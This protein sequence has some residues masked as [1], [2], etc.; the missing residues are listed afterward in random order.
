MVE[1]SRPPT[2][3]LPGAWL[4]CASARIHLIQRDVRPVDP[5]ADLREASDPRHICVDVSDLDASER[6][7]AARGFPCHRSGTAG[8]QT[9]FRTSDG[10][11]FEL[12][13]LVD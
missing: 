5:S 6:A 13:R 8:V 4:Q 11:M 7:L 12:Q 3:D 10:T 1:V 2:I 9:W